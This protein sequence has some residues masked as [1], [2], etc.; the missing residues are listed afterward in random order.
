[1]GA[2]NTWLNTTLKAVFIQHLGSFIKLFLLSLHKCR[3]DSQSKSEVNEVSV[4]NESSPSPNKS[5]FE[6]FPQ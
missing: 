2:N 5:I 6:P 4:S 3:I 1:M